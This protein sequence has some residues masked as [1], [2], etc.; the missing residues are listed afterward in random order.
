MIRT[1]LAMLVIV[2]L[3]A[4]VDAQSR[5]E[6]ARRLDAVEAQFA[7]AEAQRIAQMD[8]L[9]SRL[10]DL[11]YQVQDATGQI[12]RLQFEN[13]QLEQTSEAQG[14]E[15][16][17]LRRQIE[18]LRRPAEPQYDVDGNPVADSTTQSGATDTA[19]GAPSGGPRDL[20]GGG[21]AVTDADDPYADDRAAATRPL[22]Q[23]LASPEDR[24][25]PMS[26]NQ[27]Y[28]QARA[29]LLDG[30]FDGAQEDFS[31]FIANFPDDE[32][33]DEAWF[34]LG[35]T[36]YVRGDYS[37]A[38]EA[39]ISSLREERNGSLAPDA[40]V[41]LA[42]SLAALGRNEEACSTLARFS[43]EFPSAGPNAR[44]R[45][46]RESLRAGCR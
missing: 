17:S 5:R 21:L 35:E 46:E 10:S 34:W 3:A 41:R 32:L 44:A 15:I 7:E 13:R 6:L 30:D 26:P 16:E 40:L 36:H 4:P 23:R 27:A 43:R 45:A 24:T 19:S 2:L 9:L 1:S 29:K 8:Q 42:S 14:R 39:Y 37:S 11:E 28:G 33:I 12:E 31:T 38:A 20:T 18:R 25:P 22:G